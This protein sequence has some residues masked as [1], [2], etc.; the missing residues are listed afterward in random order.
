MKIID[1]RRIE[2][3]KTE[4]EKYKYRKVSYYYDKD[5]FFDGVVEIIGD[6]SSHNKC[7]IISSENANDSVLAPGW[8]FFLERKILH[9]VIT[10]KDDPEYFL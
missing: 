5:T 2:P 7:R 4:F 1:T 9:T 8:E 6:T 10:K 3:Y